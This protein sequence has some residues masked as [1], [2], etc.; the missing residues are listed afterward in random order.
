MHLLKKTL[1]LLS[2]MAALSLAHAVF[3]QQVHRGLSMLTNARTKIE[4]YCCVSK[5]HKNR[6]CQ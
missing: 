5:A 1:I 2:T 3:C 4:H 6:L